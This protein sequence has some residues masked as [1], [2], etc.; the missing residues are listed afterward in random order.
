VTRIV[1][2]L[3]AATEIV[4]ALG[5]EDSL[6]GIS[7]ECDYPP[8]VTPLPRVTLTTIDQARAGVEIDAE[9]RRLRSAGK[10]VIGVDADQLVALAPDVILTQDLCEVCA[11][12]D[13]EVHRLARSLD[14]LPR[15]ISLTA[16]D[17]GGIWE[18]IRVVGEAIGLGHQARSLVAALRQRL[19][20]L[21]ADPPAPR[22]RVVCIEWLD[23][24]YLAGHWVPQLIDAAGGLDVGAVAGSHS[25][26]TDWERIFAGAPDLVIVAICGF[27]I[28]RSFKELAALDDNHWLNSTSSPVW[29]LDGNAFTSRPGPR[30]VEGAALIQSAMRG[31]ERRGLARYMKPSAD[32]ADSAPSKTK[33]LS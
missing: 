31:I 33:L 28:E 13:G 21:A 22:P 19:S 14:P 10:A 27:G 6:V 29:V 30:V 8:S 1:S 26:V 12:V 20:S 9:V 7:H 23:P 16:R 2:L 25:V 15:M 24:L 3:P 18:D 17:L 4:C 11:V 32:A 5:A